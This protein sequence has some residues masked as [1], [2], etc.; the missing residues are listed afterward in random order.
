MIAAVALAR[1]E[2]VRFFRQPSRIIG[3]VSMDMI[4]VD[5]TDMPAAGLGSVVELWG[6]HV[7]LDDVATA[8]GTVNYEL[9]C[10][11]ALRV[12]AVEVGNADA[13]AMSG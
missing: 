9:L 6:E 12:P 10:A 11:L 7:S 2:L 1:R 3:R 13:S 8:A 5:L 4:S